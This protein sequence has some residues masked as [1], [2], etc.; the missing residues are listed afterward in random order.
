[1]AASTFVPRQ[2]RSNVTANARAF[3]A[4]QLPAILTRAKRNQLSAILA[5]A[6]R[7]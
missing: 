3:G 2:L 5:R 6:S 4:S 7:V 1:M